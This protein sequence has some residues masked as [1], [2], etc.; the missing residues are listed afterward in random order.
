MSVQR[1]VSKIKEYFSDDLLKILTRIHYSRNVC[2]INKDDMDKFLAKHRNKMHVMTI[3]NDVYSI[4]IRDNN[5]KMCIMKAYIDEFHWKG[6]QVNFGTGTNRLAVMTDNYVFKIGVDTAGCVDNLHEF[7]V[8][9]KYQPYVS[10]CYETNELIAV[11]EYVRVIRDQAEF[12]SRKSE[13]MKALKDLADM[14]SLMLDVGFVMKNM[15]NW[16]IRISD[17]KAVIL[18]YGYLYQKIDMDNLTCSDE[19]CIKKNG[20]QLLKYNETYSEM[21]CPRC[22]AKYG[23]MQ[24]QCLITEEARRLM[25]E[26]ALDEATSVDKEVTYYEIDQYGTKNEIKFEEV[27]PIMLINND[28]LKLDKVQIKKDYIDACMEYKRQFNF[29]G[30]VTDEIAQTREALRRKYLEATNLLAYDE[31][32]YELQDMD[33]EEELMQELE[34]QG[35]F[36]LKPGNYDAQVSNDPYN[37][38]VNKESL[39]YEN[40]NEDKVSDVWSALMK[41]TCVFDTEEMKNQ[42]IEDA[43]YASCGTSDPVI[44]GIGFKKEYES[45]DNSDDIDWAARVLGRTNLSAPV[46]EV[47]SSTKS[48]SYIPPVEEIRKNIREEAKEEEETKYPIESIPEDAASRCFDAILAADESADEEA[49]PENTNNQISAS[50]YDEDEEIIGGKQRFSKKAKKVWR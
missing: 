25:Y 42:K 30:C 38:Y 32:P 12:Y 16:G 37:Q 11:C 44:E 8:S 6:K 14:T 13:I 23:V 17:N 26:G 48:K 45:S 43:Y 9:D 47:I 15:T 31:L 50:Y 7:Y 22:G 39:S 24:L 46:A 3:E 20:V 27:D 49:T 35:I 41:D 1:Y 2:K 4:R 33:V 29:R 40:I 21:I 36:D 18:D 5:E 28:I 34:D 10:I 19:D